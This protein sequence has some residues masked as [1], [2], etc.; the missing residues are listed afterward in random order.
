MHR[1]AQTTA[2]CAT[3]ALLHNA[4]TDSKSR[5]KSFTPSDFAPQGMFGESRNRDMT[6]QEQKE[7]LLLATEL[8]K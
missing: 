6:W 4:L 3:A 7:M 1:A 2:L 5:A 8:F